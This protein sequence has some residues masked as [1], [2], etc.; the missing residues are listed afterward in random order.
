MNQ[1]PL[2]APL[3]ALVDFKRLRAQKDVEVMVCATNV[4]TARRRTFSNA[5]I[6]TD[7]VLA[8]AC[9]PDLFP[10]V[11]IGGDA[12][13]DGGYTGNPALLPLLVKLPGC[14]VVMVRIDPV[15]RDELPRSVR[16]IHDR[17]LE[18]SF[19]A[20]SW[21]E[22]AAVGMLL[23]FVEHGLLDRERF[24]RFRFHAVLS[25][26][27]EKIPASSKLNNYPAFLEYL[28]NAGRRTAEAWFAEHGAALGKQS[29]INLQRLIQASVLADFLQ[30]Q[31]DA[32]I[33]ET[34]AAA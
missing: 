23:T 15:V 13:W 4:R 16:D 24:D 17:V 32:A 10:A 28:F 31:A 2:R 11:Q 1:N 18:I 8:S 27:L 34:R 14:D 21:M 6:S 30:R 9:L 20:A 12:Y 25:S 19:N 3:D 26:D 22:I 7:A 29:T 33:K 5:D